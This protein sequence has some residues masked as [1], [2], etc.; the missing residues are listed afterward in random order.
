ARRAGAE[1]DP[2]VLNPKEADIYKA[3]L[4]ASGGEAAK[5]WHQ[6][7]EEMIKD[8]I[9]LPLISPNLILAY[10]SD[11]KGVRYSACCNLP[12]AELSH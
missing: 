11:V 5:L 1:R 8:R 3:A 9:I 4:A 10:K 6:A 12:L 7:G 2:S